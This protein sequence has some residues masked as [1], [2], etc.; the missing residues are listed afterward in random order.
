MRRLSVLLVSAL[1][2]G[3]DTLAYYGQA[4]HGQLE[5]VRA[6]RPVAEVLEDPAT[7]DTLRAQLQLA[8]SI[9]DFAVRAL[10]LPDNA[11]FRHYVALGRQFPVWNVVAAPEFSVK[12][13]Q[14]CFPVA[15]CVSYRGFFA[16]EDAA[17]FA[18]VRRSEGFDVHAYGVPAYSTLGWF[19]D[20]LLSSFIGYA[21]AELARL[22]FHELSHQVV[23]VADDTTFNES[24]AVAVEEAGVQRWL[25]A[26]GRT[27]DLVAFRLAQARKIEFVTLVGETRARLEAVYAMTLSPEAMRERKRGAFAAMAARYAALKRAWGGFAGYDR[28][29]VSPNNALIAS[30][31]TYT[32]QVP[33]FRRL[34][35]ASGGDFAVFHARVRALAAMPAAERKAA[36]R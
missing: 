7:S 14:S 34:L 9:R 29:M 10:S 22:V 12:P 4:V 18:T 26:Q 15:G 17:R 8:G 6:A 36:L 3:C 1:L 31:T 21:D 27:Q 28:L 30:I 13:A 11:S 20:P 16:H 2:A 33:G 19:T 23:Y 32:G 25:S 35:A 24:F 5:L